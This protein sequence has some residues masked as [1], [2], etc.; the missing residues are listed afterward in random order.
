[1]KSFVLRFDMLALV[2][3]HPM[4]F[5]LVPE[6]DLRTR[7]VRWDRA[8]ALDQRDNGRASADSARYINPSPNA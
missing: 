6:T 3:L 7:I 1:M 4:I 2:I 8:L 5:T